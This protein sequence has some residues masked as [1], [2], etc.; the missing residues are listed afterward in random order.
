MW[1]KWI[2]MFKELPSYIAR[3]NRRR[4]AAPSS[5][6]SQVSASDN[7]F[8][9]PSP[10]TMG[11]NGDR[12]AQDVFLFTRVL[13]PENM[14]EINA[15]A[16]YL[17]LQPRGRVLLRNLRFWLEI[18][19][20]KSLCHAQ[21]SQKLIQDKVDISAL[22]NMVTVVRLRLLIALL[23]ELNKVSIIMITLESLLYVLVILQ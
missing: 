14:A 12:R 1:E 16:D 7:L 5:A 17:A 21:G 22:V 4:A 15:F 2:P 6:V 18:Q 13:D 10:H 3:Q 9:M 19:R 20:F 8:E 11:R 23:L